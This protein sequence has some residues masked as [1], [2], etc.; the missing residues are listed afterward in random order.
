M[1]ES[2]GSQGQW[3]KKGLVWSEKKVVKRDKIER[4][5]FG[6]N[7]FK[8]YFFLELI[9]DPNWFKQKLVLEYLCS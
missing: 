4:E 8:I 3:R 5:K 2:D 1:V 9:F 6:I 7:Q